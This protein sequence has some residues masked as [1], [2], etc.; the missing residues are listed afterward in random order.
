M[1][2]RLEGKTVMVTGAGTGFGATLVERT[3]RLGLGARIARYWEEQGLSV[4]LAIPRAS[5]SS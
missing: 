4:E 2:G 3:A 5:L 1:S